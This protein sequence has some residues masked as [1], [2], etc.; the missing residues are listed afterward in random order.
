[1]LL[2]QATWHTL[3]NDLVSML[4]PLFLR[5]HPNSMSVLHYAWNGQVY[6]IHSYEHTWF[7]LAYS[8]LECAS[9]T[10]LNRL[11]LYCAFAVM[12]KES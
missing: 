6:S 1:M 7:L 10:Q 8:Q 4:M 12:L 11:F 2:I 5:N 9:S 3:R